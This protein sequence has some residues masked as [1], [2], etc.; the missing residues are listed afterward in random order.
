MV[1][2]FAIDYRFKADHASAVNGPQIDLRLGFSFGGRGARSRAHAAGTFFRP[3]ASARRVF[4][5]PLPGAATCSLSLSGPCFRDATGT[6]GRENR[7]AHRRSQ[8]LCTSR[9]ILT[10]NSGFMFKPHQQLSGV[11]LGRAAGRT[12]FRLRTA[13]YFPRVLKFDHTMRHGLDSAAGD[14]ALGAHA[15][16]PI[17]RHMTARKSLTHQRPS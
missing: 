16:A 7:A 1:G 6:T 13:V 8:L 17:G 5:L 4:L 2:W 9:G 10:T 12:V 15:L 14:S 11:V 3:V